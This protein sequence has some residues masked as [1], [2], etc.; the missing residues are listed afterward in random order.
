MGGDGAANLIQL[1]GAVTGSAVLT[2]IVNG[3]WGRR[4]MSAD[5]TSVIQKA[6]STAVLRSDAD[7]ARLRVENDDV[8]RRERETDHENAVLL[9]ALRDYLPYSRRLAGEVRRLGGV[10]EEPP[11]L[12]PT[13]SI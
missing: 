7:N 4:K 9:D 13:L 12:P 11:P 6:A 3:F 5:A 8:R 2:S 10:P 1:L